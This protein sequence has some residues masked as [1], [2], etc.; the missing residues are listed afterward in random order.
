MRR[1]DNTLAS[2]GDICARSCHIM[3]SA[4]EDLLAD[5]AF[6]ADLMAALDSDVMAL[7]GA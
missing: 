5:S 2:Q 6:E 1:I 7:A 3:M 4:D